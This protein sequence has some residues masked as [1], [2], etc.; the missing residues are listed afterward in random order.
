MTDPI[1]AQKRVRCRVLREL[2]T[3][4]QHSQTVRH[5]NH[6][7]GASLPL[8]VGGLILLAL[9]VIALV[10]WSSSASTSSNESIQEVHQIERGDFLIKIP[11]TGELSANQLIEIRN[12]LET[13]GTINEIIE[14]GAF[15]QEGDVLI[16]LNEDD[17]EQKIKEVRDRLVEDQNRVVNAEQTLAIG[18]STMES[19]LEKADLAIDI[20]QLALQ[21]WREGEHLQKTQKFELALETATINADRLAKRFDE[22][23]ELVD[24]GFISRDEYE[25]DRI[26]KI[27]SAAAVK[28][29]EIDLDVY[30]RFTSKQDEKQKISDTDQAVAERSRVK[31][32][33]DAELVTQNANV[34]SAQAKHAST[35]ERLEEL[36]EQFEL[37]TIT[38]PTSGLVVY[39][40]SMRSDRSWRSDDSPPTIGTSL[41]PNELVIL[42][43]DT[44]QM[45]ANVKV[46]EAL[47]GRIQ[48]GMQTTTYSEA[49][50]NT[51][52]TGVVQG[53]SVLAE[54][55]GWRD[56]NRRDYTVR[57]ALSADPSME[58]KPSMRCRSEI[59]LGTVENAI[60]VPI[61]SVFRNG[62][63]A[64]VYT[65]EAGG[66]AEK[67]VTLGRSSELAVEIVGGVDV[68][69]IVLLREPEAFEVVSRL[70]SEELKSASGG[71][72]PY[73]G[74]PGSGSGRPP[75]GTTGRPSGTSSGGPPKGTTTSKS[76]QKSPPRKTAS[77]NEAG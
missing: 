41:S 75:V 10:A 7:R 53:V 17:I 22:A 36:Q 28:Q 43:P 68:G 33:H 55:G 11:A 46:S 2:K 27:E 30:T 26:A 48:P 13:K 64:F 31:Q 5:S 1:A 45:I 77:T 72:P 21:A 23:K 35:K 4:M 57:I 14:E 25:R 6:P 59:L 32:R 24:N 61:Q 51:P 19:N 12:P 60:S 63:H 39:R 76:D 20:A 66:W 56:P 65:P 8:I 49:H 74:R 3:T 52:I 16:R 29:A 18:K 73:T 34:Q 44:S 70:S 67:K 50:P 54:G 40:T 42:L 9:F 69:D 47:S 15:V 58:L 38:A 37:C 62:P 71:R